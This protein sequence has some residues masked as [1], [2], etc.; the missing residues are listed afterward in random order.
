MSMR[1]TLA[2]PFVGLA[3]TGALARADTFSGFSGVDRPYLVNQDRVCQPLAVAS[4]AA[5]GLPRCDKAA[6]D[7]I[8]RLSIKPPMVQ[9]GAK[10]S[11]AA[12][13]SGRT[14]T[15]SRKTGGAI[16]AWDAP[17]PVVRIVDAYAS[18]YDDRVAVAYVVR[19]AGK[20]VTDVVAFDLGQGQTAIAPG[21][22]APGAGSG[23]AGA[24]SNAGPTSVTA[25]IIQPGQP[26]QPGPDTAAAPAAEPPPDPKVAKAIADARAAPRAKTV[27]AWTAVLAVAP[28][29][30]EALFRIAV[31][32]LA[33]HNTAQALEALQALSTSPHADAVEWRVEARFDPAFAALR[34]DP[35]FRAA[36]GL[37]RKSAT[38]YERLMGF[39]GQWEQTGTSCDKPEVRF[40]ATRDRK[41][42]LRVKT[43]CEGQ[44]YD[45]PFQGTWRLDGERVVLVLPTHGRATSAAD[46]AICGFEPAGD[47][48][49]LR[50]ELSHDLDFVVLPTRR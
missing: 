45:T 24:G 40:I 3:L 38:P 39:G 37:D 8:A 4:N 16:V 12:Q 47:E 2:V 35:K 1:R 18:Q 11:F 17:D 9:S 28:G 26:G 49:A 44:I 23:A 14:I 6:A 41:F 5:T 25:R 33:A 29:H 13:A 21:P 27:A 50:C 30:A 31:A 46:E 36:V 15:V 19:R 48:D 32:Q 34:A 42:R 20:E 10:A 43:S 7:V 22:A